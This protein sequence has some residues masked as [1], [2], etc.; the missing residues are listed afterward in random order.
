MKKIHDDRSLNVFFSV[1]PKK[2]YI[3]YI[4][5]YPVC[6]RIGIILYRFFLH[7]IY[8]Y[9]SSFRTLFMI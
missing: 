4:I 8:V 7:N 1:R 2:K 3:I 6:P 5:N 9:I